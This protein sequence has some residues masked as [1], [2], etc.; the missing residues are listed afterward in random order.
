MEKERDFF[1][2]FVEGDSHAFQEY[3]CINEWSSFCI[4]CIVL[5]MFVCRSSLK[6]KMEYGE[7]T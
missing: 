2:D 6:E 7:M 1:Q 5:L 4:I 3:V